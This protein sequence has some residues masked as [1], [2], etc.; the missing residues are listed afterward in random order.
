MI[1]TIEQR[2]KQLQLKL[3]QLEVKERNYLLGEGL[4][5]KCKDEQD[6]IIIEKLQVLQFLIGC[7]MIDESKTVF[8][9]EGVHKPVFLEEEMW[10]LKG[11]IIELVKK[12]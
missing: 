8:G 2:E 11:K 4:E 3:K 10:I 5:K 7:S 6:R 12:L 1:K 9:S